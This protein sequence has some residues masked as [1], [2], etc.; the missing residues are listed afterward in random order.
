MKPGSNSVTWRAFTLMEM[1]VVVG[2]LGML[3]ALLLPV[4]SKA[5]S[6]SRAAKCKNH[7]SQLGKAMAM[8]EGDNGYLP[9]AGDTALEVN[10][11]ITAS[12]D[13]WIAKLDKYVA[14][15]KGV[16][17]CPDNQPE[18]VGTNTVDSYGYNAVGTEMLGSTNHWGLGNGKG[19][20]VRSS[21]IKSPA[22]MVAIGDLQLPHSVWIN[23]I[24]PRIDIQLGGQKSLIASRHSGGAN[25]FFCDGHVEWARQSVWTGSKPE[26]SSRWNKD[27]QPHQH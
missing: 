19:D 17:I 20:F 12:L 4:L 10:K 14:G 25:M 11:N 22:D 13:S 27:H 21:E 9:G 18:V 16:S 7:L 6:T 26:Q 8:Y 24:N 23:I 5:Q 1:L 2:I 3:A 15:S